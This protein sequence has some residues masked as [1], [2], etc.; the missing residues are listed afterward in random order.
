MHTFSHFRLEITPLECRVLAAPAL[1]D[2]PDRL[3]Y[4]PADPARLGLA[5]PVRRL[6][7]G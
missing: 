2:A 7:A 1:L 6:L 4:N 3:W 5:A